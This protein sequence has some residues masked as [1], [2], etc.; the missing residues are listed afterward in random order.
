VF[1]GVLAGCGGFDP[2]TDPPPDPELQP[3]KV[4]VNSSTMPD[5]PCLLNVEM[6]RAVD[7]AVVVVGESGFARVTVVDDG[8]RVVFATDNA[9][10]PHD[11]RC[12][13]EHSCDSCAPRGRMAA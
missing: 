9:G 6:V 7:H 5:D 13:I 12:S 1:L 10:R 3:L 8:G 4:V 11:E 2:I